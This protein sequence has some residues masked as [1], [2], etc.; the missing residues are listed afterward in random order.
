MRP[1]HHRHAAHEQH[2]RHHQAVA[3]QR[4]PGIGGDHFSHDAH[5]RKDQHVHLWV[6]EEPEEVLPQ[7]RVAAAR[8]ALQRNAA[9][10]QPAREKE[11]RAGDAIHHLEDG[12]GLQRREGEEQQQGGNELRP[13]EERQARQRQSCAAALHDGDDHV[14]RVER[15]R[16]ADQED[17]DQPERLAGGFDHRERRVRRPAGSRGAAFDE[18][19]RDHDH[20]GKE[21]KPEAERVETRKCHL[22]RANLD[23]D[24]VVG[25]RAGGERHHGEEDH[26]RAVHRDQLVVELGQHDAA[27]RVGIAEQDGDP[28]RQRLAWPRQLPSHQDH[29]E[30]S[31][32]QEYEGG[33]AVLQA[34]R[35]VIGPAH[36][37]EAISLQRS[38]LG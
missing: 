25:E 30:K 18:E 12:R 19:A 24:E 1:Y 15:R 16:H 21:V 10:N 5:R 13:H 23:W 11:A 6:A 28:R 36:V 4:A 31:D 32:Q 37:P 17:A 22:R 38:A 20:A 29:Q 2:G 33:E 8:D 35:L 27:G 3:P 7:Q 34:Y 9:D 26:H 14:H